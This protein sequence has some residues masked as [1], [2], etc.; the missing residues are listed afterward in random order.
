MAW[1]WGSQASLI[2]LINLSVLADWG[3]VLSCERTLVHA[4]LLLVVTNLHVLRVQIHIE[5]PLVVFLILLRPL[6]VVLLYWHFCVESLLLWLLLK[7]LP[8]WRV[9]AYLTNILLWSL[10]SDLIILLNWIGLIDLRVV[11]LPNATV[12]PVRILLCLQVANCKAYLRL[13]VSVF[14]WWDSTFFLRGLSPLIL[15]IRLTVIRHRLRSRHWALR[16]M[17]LMVEHLLT[18]VLGEL[19]R[20][21]VWFCSNLML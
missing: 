13:L 19:R 15:P 2:K 14:N 21:W 4:K 11:L 16:V 5:M 1:V 10:L 7:M 12:S 3:L 20:V 17:L 6:L 18:L 8:Q 9:T